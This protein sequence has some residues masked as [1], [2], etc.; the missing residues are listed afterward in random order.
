MSGSDM[1][2]LWVLLAL[3]GISLWYIPNTVSL[4]SGQHAYYTLDDNLSQLQCT[5]C[6]G[7]ISIELHTG[8]IHSNFTCAD[9]HRVQ[10]GVQYANATEPGTLAHAASLVQC[11]DC[12][13][14]YLNNTP[15]TIHNAFINY[16]MQHNT[17]ENCI[18]CHASIAVSINWTRPDAMN[19][20]TTSDGY[21][22]TINRTYKS[23]TAR[24][25]TFGNQSGDAIAVSN[26]T[27]I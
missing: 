15:D 11:A 25:V 16:G 2:I 18:A 3:V 6:H 7:D 19:I 12:H 9:C 5:K 1:K 21:N 23:F 27:V 22:I 20:E 17:S 26:V 10:K 13:S 14:E 24:V 4:F 8:Y